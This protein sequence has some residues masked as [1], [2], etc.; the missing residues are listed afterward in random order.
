MVTDD[1]RA[2]R[3][4]AGRATARKPHGDGARGRSPREVMPFDALE[5]LNPVQREAVLHHEGPLL[6]VAG[7]GLRQDPG[8][9]A[10]HRPPDPRPRHLAVRDP[11]HHLHQ[12][13]RRRDEAAGRRAR[14][15]GGP[16]DVGVDVPLG[17][18]ADPAARGAA[19]SAS[20]R[21]SRSTTRPTPCA[22]PGTWSATSAST[23]KRFPPRSVHAHISAAKN[24]HIIA[25]AVRR[26]GRRDLR[27]QDRRRLPGV[28]GPPPAGRRHGL[29]RPPHVDGHPLPP[30][31]RRPR[32]LPAAVPA[33]AGR[34]V[35]GH[36]QGPERARPATGAA[37]TATSA[38]SATATS[39][40]T[41]S[42][43]RTCGTS[44][45][46]RRRSRTPRWSCS[47]RTT[48]RRRR[49]STRPT[50]SSP[51]T[52]AASRRSCGPTAATAA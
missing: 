28:P 25:R 38:S 32:P 48:G 18:R 51:T 44:S 17:V 7:R 39:R 23:P 15:S 24:D 42:A 37:S 41:S 29:R 49:S 5:G 13:G 2:Q 8:A 30:P 33:R 31:P 26:A 1:D 43:A 19:S 47:S 11:G 36:Q 35:P 34:R 12:Q 3:G 40:S 22:S 21:R 10:S 4:H 9:H 6:V 45:S 20:R 52:W 46:S 14:R 27:A 50:R 16:E